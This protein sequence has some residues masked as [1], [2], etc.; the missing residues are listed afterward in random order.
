MVALADLPIVVRSYRYSSLLMGT[1]R[2]CSMASAS[3]VSS[4]ILGCSS[5]DSS[6]ISRSCL[7]SGGRSRGLLRLFREALTSF[8]GGFREPLIGLFLP[9]ISPPYGSN[10]HYG[11]LWGILP[12]DGTVSRFDLDIRSS[13]AHR[14]SRGVRRD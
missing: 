5:R 9:A 4:P 8:W 3:G 6:S 2:L 12:V 1:I 14:Y 11:R 13:N 7:T 10:A